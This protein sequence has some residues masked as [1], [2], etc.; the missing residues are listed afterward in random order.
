M[1][2]A[3]FVLAI[4]GCGDG[5]ASCSEVRIVETRFTSVES[6]QQAMPGILQ[7]NTDL[8]YPELS[9]TCR[10]VAPIVASGDDQGAGK[11][12]ARG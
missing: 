7:R 12:R 6:C 11:R 4:M 3:L 2:P 1:A 8:E 10:R 5:G 9:A